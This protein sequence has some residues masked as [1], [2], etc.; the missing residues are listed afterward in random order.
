VQCTTSAASKEAPIALQSS[1]L[2]VL[3]IVYAHTNDSLPE[4]ALALTQMEEA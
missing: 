2:G 1:L 4:L 3:R